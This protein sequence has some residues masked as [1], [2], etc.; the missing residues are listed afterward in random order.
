MEVDTDDKAL[1]QEHQLKEL[2]TGVLVLYTE[3]FL[4][5]FVICR[6]RI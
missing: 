1:K 3:L 6:Y 4:N 2:L 5:I